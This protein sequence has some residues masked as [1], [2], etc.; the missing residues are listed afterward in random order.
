MAMLRKQAGLFLVLHQALDIL[1]VLVSFYAAYWTK[2]YSQ[3]GF[4]G[5]AENYNYDL[6]AMLVVISFNISLRL[7]G[8]YTPYRRFKFREIRLNLFK[9]SLTAV[10]GVIFLC[11]VVHLESVSRILLG[12]FWCYSFLLLLL[13]KHL[14]FQSLAHG[15]KR[16]YNT[17]TILVIGSRQRSLDFIK[18]VYKRKHSGYRVSGVLETQENTEL[19][20][21]RIYKSIK[22]LGTLDNY[23]DI[24]K[25]ETID[26]VIFGVPLK[27]IPDIHHYIYFAEE[28]GINVRVLP[29]FQIHRIKYFPQ[30]AKIEIED[31]LGV[32]T[33]ALSSG[34][35]NTNALFL[36]SIIDY[37]GAGIG[38]ALL[39]PV[40]FLIGFLIK[41]TSKG[42]ILYSQERSG[43]NGR[44]FKMHKFRTMVVGADKMLDELKDMNEMDGPVYKI[45]DDPRIIW[46]GKILRKTSLDELPQLFNVLKGEMSLVGPRP[47][48]PT[49]VEQYKLWQRRRLSMKPGLTCIW[50]VSGRNKISFEEWMNMD[51]IYIDNWSLFLDFKLLLQT[52]REVAIG[53]GR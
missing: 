36:K 2:I 4:G 39:S 16:N 46:I 37:T 23:R 11:Y 41:V 53:G 44:R 8:L 50:Q 24:L 43:L 20:G 26:E 29:D 38:V 25:E 30:T 47:P 15:R 10:T 14:V 48:I 22:I 27:K 18:A 49:E 40:F 42:P 32:P 52:V 13:S 21:D 31:F 45:E 1:L 7:F 9:A 35:Q 19:I 17:R 33:L 3:A 5:L 51:L 6:L 28:M 12:L 34:P